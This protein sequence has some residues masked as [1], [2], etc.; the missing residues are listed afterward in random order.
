MFDQV[1]GQTHNVDLHHVPLQQQN[2]SIQRPKPVYTPVHCSDKKKKKKLFRHQKKC[3]LF[4]FTTVLWLEDAFWV[5][6]VDPAAVRH[7]RTT[8]SSWT[9]IRIDFIPL[10]NFFILCLQWLIDSMNCLLD[11]IIFYQ[12]ATLLSKNTQTLT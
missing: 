12:A 3:V 7:S 5:G 8:E 2:G 9:L 11:I 1:K 4:R 6:F 10:T